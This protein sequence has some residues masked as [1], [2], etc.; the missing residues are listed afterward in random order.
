MRMNKVLVGVLVGLG[1]LCLICGGVAFFGGSKLF[2]AGADAQ[3]DA[4]AYANSIM[5]KLGAN[6][7]P[8]VL[9]ENASAEFLNDT[10]DAEI[11]SFTDLIRTRLGSFKSAGPYRMTSINMSNNN[12]VSRTD[13]T[14]EGPAKFEE[15]DGQLVLKLVKTNDTWKVQNL[16]IQSELLK[17]KPKADSEPPVD[18]S[19]EVE[20]AGTTTGA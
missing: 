13:V 7:N 20:S 17:G 3:K 19:V 11:V 6:W 9:K 15:G 18:D 10:T 14:L 8:A 1:A 5:P 12:G 16:D 2:Q 4:E